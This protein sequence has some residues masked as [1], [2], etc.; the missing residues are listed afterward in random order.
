[1]KVRN[2]IGTSQHQCSC[3]S[4][5][6][7]WKK[8]SGKMANKCA[9]TGCNG[10]DLVGGHVQESS[11]PSLFRK[12]NGNDWYIIPIC[13]GCNLKTEIYEVDDTVDLVSANVSK[14]CGKGDPKKNSVGFFS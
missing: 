8:L 7:H 1:M 13:K 2:I 14:T 4:W 11:G 12:K 9:A 5:L 3:G 6:N 10:T